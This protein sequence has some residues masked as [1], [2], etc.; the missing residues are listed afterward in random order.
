VLLQNKVAVI[1]GIGPGMGRETALLFAR[2]GASLAIGARTETMLQS[3]AREV[4][5]LG[6]QVIAHVTDLADRGSCQRLVRAAVEC[7]GSLWRS[8]SVPGGVA[9]DER[10]TRRPHCSHQLR[11]QQQPGAGGPIRVRG[12][13]VGAGGAGALDRAR[14]RQVRYPLQWLARPVTGQAISVNGGEWFGVR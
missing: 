3:V 12:L 11:R 1:P 4:E 7:F 6:G 10:Q 9:I 8:A 2:N 5:A 14:M 13:E